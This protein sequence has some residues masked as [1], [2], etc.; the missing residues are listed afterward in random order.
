MDEATKAAREIKA[1]EL[2]ASQVAAGGVSD[3]D[4]ANAALLARHIGSTAQELEGRG[5][6][7]TWSRSGWKPRWRPAWHASRSSP[8]SSTS[9]SEANTERSGL[10]RPRGR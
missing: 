4:E 7:D 6:A 8:T 2:C 9:R 10:S 1:A 3:T 5:M